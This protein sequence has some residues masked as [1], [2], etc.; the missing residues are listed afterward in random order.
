MFHL[1]PASVNPARP[2]PVC[3][4]LENLVCENEHG[5]ENENAPN[6][7]GDFYFWT[8]KYACQERDIL[9]IEGLAAT[10]RRPIEGSV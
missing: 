5:N 2:W 4:E 9:T 7:L 10:I 6:I 3:L 1:A 8:V